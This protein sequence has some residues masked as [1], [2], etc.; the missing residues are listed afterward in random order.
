MN[1]HLTNIFSRVFVA[2]YIVGGYIRYYSGRITARVAVTIIL[3]LTMIA[4]LTMNFYMKPQINGNDAL[5]KGYDLA[6]SGQLNA[7][8]KSFEEAYQVFRN[9][10]YG[11]G[12]FVA[13]G[14]LG[15]IDERLS[16]PHEALFH[17]DA[18]LRLAQQYDDTDAQISLFKKHADIKL[19]LNRFDAARA[20]LYDAIKIAQDTENHEQVA[21]LFTRVGNLER[22]IG[23]DRQARFLY[24]QASDT[25]ENK[26]NLAGQ[27]NLNWNLGILEAGLENYDAA[28][29]EY[30][31]ARELFK[32]INDTYR[33]AIVVHHMARLEKKL[34]TERNAAT[35]YNEAA[36]LYASI[37]RSEEVKSLKNEAGGLIL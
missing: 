32:T 11:R 12:M 2:A 35:L 28:L 18:A 7:A 14:K 33:E 31:T 19:R 21:F 37:G 24:R 10:N 30:I 4:G 27:A 1:N 22:N 13:L 29:H 17:Y 20:H 23:N 5:N 26:P 34:G 3:V 15:E 8:H 16:N 36:T 6:N 9:E 25:Y